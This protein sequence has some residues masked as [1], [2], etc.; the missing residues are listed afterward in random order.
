VSAG[1]QFSVLI[2]V[3]PNNA[4]AGAQFSLSFDPSLVNVIGVTEGN[5]LKQGGANTYF[6]AGE[7]NNAAG[8]ISGVAGAIITP[9]QTVS[10]SGT[11]ATIT[12]AAG[13]AQGT[14]PLNLSNVIVGDIS[15]HSVTANIINGQVVNGQASNGQASTN[16]PPM[17]SPIGSKSVNPG[18]LLIFTISGSDPDGDRLTY[19]ASNLPVGATFNAS[20]RMFSWTPTSNQVGTYRNVHF[21]VSDGSLTASGDIS[22]T[23]NGA[24]GA[25]RQ[26]MLNPIGGKSVN[27]GALL[28]FTVSA[29]DPDGDPLAYSASNLPAGATFNAS[30]RTFS[31]TPTSSQAGT[32]PSVHFQ[33]SD[34]SLTASEDITIMVSAISPVDQAPSVNAIGNRSVTVGQLLQFD[35]SAT[36]PNGDKLSYSAS[37]LPSGATFDPSTRTFSWTPTSGQV[38][39]YSNVRFQASDGSLASWED[40]TIT[41][42]GPASG[43]NRPP[44]LSAVGSKSVGSGAL[45]IFTISGSD[46]DGDRLNYSASNLPA[47]AMFNAAARLFSWTPTSRQVGPYPGI[48]FEVFDGSLVDSQDITITVTAPVSGPGAG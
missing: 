47:G 40:V 44:V 32:Y 20:A 17:L 8:A 36:D 42:S 12:F 15:G 5:L 22:I 18:A 21:Q 43:A 25:N 48:H 29:T 1:Q 4:I 39:T 13:T 46:P 23:V 24:P 11:F 9:G 10:S 45:L 35:V 31:W 37:N 14:C 26:P 30:A 28:T 19:S 41:V 16:R 7:I 33:V 27:P 38:G 6:M 3:D 2:N 34:G